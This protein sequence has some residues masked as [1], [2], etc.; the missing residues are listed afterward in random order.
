MSNSIE[1]RMPIE[2]EMTAMGRNG[3]AWS[4]G[5]HA[6]VP[7]WEPDKLVLTP[8]TSKGHVQN[9]EIQLTAEAMTELATWWLARHPSA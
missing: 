4:I 7:G 1:I 5:V 9:C 2:R 3:R 8:I 6:F